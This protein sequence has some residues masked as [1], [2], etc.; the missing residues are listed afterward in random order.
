M[1][2]ET[3]KGPSESTTNVDGSTVNVDSTTAAPAAAKPSRFWTYTKYGAGIIGAAL[4][5]T[6]VVVMTRTMGASATAE[7]VAET[8]AA[9]RA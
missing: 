8:A 1:T 9:L 3:P 4:T 7:V 5:V 2:N 6:A